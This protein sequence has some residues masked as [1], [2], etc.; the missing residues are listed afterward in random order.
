[1]PLC[2][3]LRSRKRKP[4]QRLSAVPHFG[5]TFQ[6]G[7]FAFTGRIDVSMGSACLAEV[8]KQWQQI[9]CYVFDVSWI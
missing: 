9:Q 2:K 1:M 8:F 3:A 5:P 7:I 6:S 4:V